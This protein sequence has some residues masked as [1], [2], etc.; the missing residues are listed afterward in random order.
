MTSEIETYCDIADRN[1]YK[2]FKIDRT[3]YSISKIYICK[4]RLVYPG[5]VEWIDCNIDIS[6]SRLQS[7]ILLLKID[8]SYYNEA[9]D[10]TEQNHSEIKIW[11]DRDL[12]SILQQYEKKEN[13]F[14]RLDQIYIQSEYECI[15][16]QD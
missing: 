7:N 12:I 16:Q 15:S 3:K 14:D 5:K 10:Q 13:I 2:L 8:H 6:K 1:V 4:Y 9:S 11:Y